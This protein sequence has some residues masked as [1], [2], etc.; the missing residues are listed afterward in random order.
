VTLVPS[1]ATVRL[2]VDCN[3]RCVFCAQEGLKASHASVGEQLADA[4]ARADEV[5]LVGGEPTLDAQLVEHVAG[6]RALGFVRV[7]VQTNAREL[8]AAGL[9]PRLAAAGLTDVHLSIHGP[10]AAVHDYHTGAQ[11]SFEQALGAM[12]AARAA[13]LAVVVA[14]VL[15]RSSFRSLAPMPM[16]LAARGATGW[17]VVVPAVAGRAR[18]G[19]DRVVPR[20]GMALP[21][22]LSALDA[23]EALGMEVHVAGAPRCLLGPFAR[24]ALAELP[25]T[26]AP[27]CE[28]CPARSACPGLEEAYLE[29]F[30][31]DELEA[32]RA[33]M[34]AARP[35]VA[36][37]TAVARMFVGA[38]ELALGPAVE[39]RRPAKVSLPIAGKARPANGEATATSPKKSGEALR[40]IL[41]S[42][43][44]GDDGG[45]S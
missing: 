23:G 27:V 42:L 20:L 24:W 13:G 26:F 32:A 3:N 12:G 8:A 44:E 2:P 35:K 36:E 41:P 5:T 17:L 30:G 33:R 28:G 10:D 39:P 25:R 43:F 22:A 18:A 34:D 9:L 7:G 19:F 14:T 15:T 1:R 11:G 4:R 45:K 38:G 29:R 16:L 6:A 31:G 40:A 21:F 37:T